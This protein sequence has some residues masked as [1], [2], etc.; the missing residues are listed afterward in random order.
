[1][2][3]CLF[4]PCSTLLRASTFDVECGQVYLGGMVSSSVGSNSNALNRRSKRSTTTFTSPFER[5]FCVITRPWNWRTY[6]RGNWEE[7]YSLTP[8]ALR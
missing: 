7:G 8:T 6:S 4:G 5:S 3:D 1:M 2:R